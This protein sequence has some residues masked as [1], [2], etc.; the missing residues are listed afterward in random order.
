M[1]IILVRHGETKESKKGIILGRLPGALSQK[2]KQDMKKLALAIKKLEINPEIIFSSDLERAK[3]S[4]IILSGVLSLKIKYDSLLRERSGGVAEG[5][6]ENQIDWEIYEKSELL[7][8]KHEGGESFIDV[9][10]RAKKFLYKFTISN[11]RKYKT[12]I[13]VS[14]SVLLS[15]LLSCI[16]RWSIKKSLEFKFRGITILEIKTGARY[17]LPL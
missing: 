16:K 8:R 5:K 2:G 13:V 11:S 10:S 6:R 1:K 3:E 7:Y 4:S 14:H 12:V 9:K 15:M 17:T